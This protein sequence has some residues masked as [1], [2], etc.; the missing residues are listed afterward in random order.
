[1]G[2]SRKQLVKDM[3]SDGAFAQAGD[4][5]SYLRD[6]FK[7]ILQ[8]M[9]EQEMVQELGYE[10]GDSVNK[11]TNNRRNEYSKKVVK[12]QFRNIDL[13]IPRDRDND[14]NPVV[15]P[16]NVR[17][18]SGIEEKVISL[19][20]RGMSTRY[21]HD[22]ILDLYGIEISADQVINITNVVIERAKEW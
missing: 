1:M 20:A 6:M 19:Y 12:S 9:V 17:D 10:K 4:I 3:I 22:P 16:K 13:D 21:I 2:T 7:D 11:N 5:S 18:I 8:E 15:I 14:F